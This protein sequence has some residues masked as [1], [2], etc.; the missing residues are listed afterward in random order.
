MWENEIE[1]IVI[2]KKEKPPIFFFAC[3]FLNAVCALF[4]HLLPISIS[5]PSYFCFPLE[6]APAFRP[7]QPRMWRRKNLC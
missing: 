4:L 1:T 3:F 6:I 7:N 5:R 2:I